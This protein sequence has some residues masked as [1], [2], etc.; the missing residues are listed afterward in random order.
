MHSYRYIA[1]KQTNTHIQ[2]YEGKK[3]LLTNW[4]PHI[5]RN[6]ARAQTERPMLTIYWLKEKA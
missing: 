6:L 2:Q 3:N 4:K 1:N 5:W